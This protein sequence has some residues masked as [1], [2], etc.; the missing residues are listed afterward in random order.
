MLDAITR[1][2]LEGCGLAETVSLVFCW[3]AQIVLRLSLSWISCVCVCLCC[4][5]LL[6]VSL[7]VLLF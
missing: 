3:A 6:C 2:F 5:V 7:V 4:F 1:T